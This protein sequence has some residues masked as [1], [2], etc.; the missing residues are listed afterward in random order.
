MQLPKDKREAE[1]EGMKRKVTRKRDECK[2]LKAEYEERT[3]ER[4]EGAGGG[5]VKGG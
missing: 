3:R 2:E 4:C 5:A 1:L